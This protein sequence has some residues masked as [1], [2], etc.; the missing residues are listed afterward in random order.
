M[1]RWLPKDGC[2]EGRRE[3]VQVDL[4]LFSGGVIFH[5]ES[6]VLVS[7]DGA[8]IILTGP[9]RT[10]DVDVVQLVEI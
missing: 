2:G 1:S 8:K 6:Y 7:N 10:Q 9:Q 5:N 4:A 3:C